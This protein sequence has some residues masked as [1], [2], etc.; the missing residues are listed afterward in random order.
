MLSTQATPCIPCVLTTAGCPASSAQRSEATAVRL[1]GGRRHAGPRRRAATLVLVWNAEHHLAILELVSKTLLRCPS[2][3]LDVGFIV[4][5]GH[6]GLHH[7]LETCFL[8]SPGAPLGAAARVVAA[9]DSGMC[10]ST[11]RYAGRGGHVGCR[12]RAS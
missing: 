1:M 10:C 7:M 5:A 8:E 4:L 12:G 9:S 6:T 2:Q 3:G 11:P